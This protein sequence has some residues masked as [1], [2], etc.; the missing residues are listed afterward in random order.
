[1]PGGVGGQRREPLPTRL[2]IEYI[3]ICLSNLV[4]VELFKVWLLI[5]LSLFGHQWF[6]NKNLAYGQV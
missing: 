2:A 3:S 1:M 5:I 4:E 6:K